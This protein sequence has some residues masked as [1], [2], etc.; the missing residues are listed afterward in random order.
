MKPVLLLLM[1]GSLG[2]LSG[3][4]AICKGP[5]STVRLNVPTPI[6]F[7]NY[8]GYEAALDLDGQHELV[9]T[10]GQEYVVEYQRGEYRDSMLLERKL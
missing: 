1:L 6:E 8:S 5:N 10:S 3:C 2:A 9:V 7:H 4:A